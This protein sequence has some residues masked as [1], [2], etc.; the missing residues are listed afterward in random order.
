MSTLLWHVEADASR[1][2][3]LIS[4]EANQRLLADGASL[5]TIIPRGGNHYRIA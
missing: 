2:D 5:M 4:A 1:P 3:A